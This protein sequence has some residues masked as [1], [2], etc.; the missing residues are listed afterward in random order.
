MAICA[1]V[2]QRVARIDRAAH[3]RW[4][5]RVERRARTIFAV[6]RRSRSARRA[7]RRGWSWPECLFE[8]VVA[9]ERIE[10]FA[11]AVAWSTAG[12]AIAMNRAGRINRD[13][14]R[15]I[16]RRGVHWRITTGAD[17]HGCSQGGGP[18]CA[19]PRSPQQRPPE[20]CKPFLVRRLRGGSHAASSRRVDWRRGYRVNSRH[21][22]IRSTGSAG[23]SLFMRICL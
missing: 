11:I 22:T 9:A 17:S 1:N 3:C 7:L 16:N 15:R 10:T 18:G 2:A 19:L 4:R 20:P 14:M 21:D 8:I 13:D 23:C 5:F 12:R 6:V